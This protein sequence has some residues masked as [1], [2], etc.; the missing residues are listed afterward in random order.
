[1]LLEVVRAVIAR[2][3]IEGAVGALFPAVEGAVAVRTPVTSGASATMARSQL[4]QALTDFATELAGLATVLEVEELGGGIAVGATASLRQGAGTASSNRRQRLPMLALILSTQL[5]PVQGRDSRR[6]H[7]GLSQRG[8]GINVKVAVVRMLL[9]KVVA[10]LRF[11]LTPGENLLQLLDKFLQ[12]LAGKFPTEPKHQAWYAAHGG[13]SLGN[14]AGS[15]K[16]DIGKRDFTAFFTC[17]QLP[18]RKLQPECTKFSRLANGPQPTTPVGGRKQKRQ[19][20]P[21]IQQNMDLM[22]ESL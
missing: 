5:L 8:L 20:L 19:L 15:L 22:K 1:L 6:R 12:I 2:T 13:E 18:T 7:G 9:A 14:L 17:R 16:A 21:R 11:G 4:R 10:R 3:L